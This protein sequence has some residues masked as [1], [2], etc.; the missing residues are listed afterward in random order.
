MVDDTPVSPKSMRDVCPPRSR[1]IQTCYYMQTHSRPEQIERLVRLIKEG[2]P[3]STVLIDHDASVAS[4]DTRIFRPMSGV[5]VI[6]GSGGYGDFSHLDRYFTAVDWLDSRGVDFDWFQNLTGQDYPLRPIGDIEQALLYGG[7]DGYLQY[8]PVFPERTPPNVDWGAGPE[9]RLASQFDTTMRI[10]YAHRFV[11]RPTLTKQR[12]LR[13]FMVA[14]WMQPWVRVC[15]G[16]STVGIRRKDTIF[17]DDF[18]CYGGSFYCALSATCVRYARD[19][20]RANPDIVKFFRAVCG[21]EE[22][23]LQTALV[24]SG[25][26]RLACSGTHYIDFSNSHYNHPKTFA[27]TDLEV[28][29]SSGAHWARKFN[30]DYDSRILDALDQHVRV[31]S[32][33]LCLSQINIKVA[34]SY[35]YRKLPVTQRPSADQYN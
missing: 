10:D 2:S 17:N 15:L 33:Y 29:L 16:Y 1:P 35:A 9:Y 24:N 11:G 20:A 3:S 21:P 23:F 18:I 31:V 34:I 14:N 6:N 32:L 8:A 25:K 26:F 22:L 13:P 5:H 12:L 19:F 7:Y 30:S 27:V 4:L 28:L